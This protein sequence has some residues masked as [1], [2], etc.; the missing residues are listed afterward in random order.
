MMFAMILRCASTGSGKRAYT[1]T[2]KSL[3]SKSSLQESLP[4]STFH[5]TLTAGD[6]LS[7]AQTSGK[8]TSEASRNHVSA[9]LT[10]ISQPMRIFREAV[11][12]TWSGT[13]ASTPKTQWKE[14]LWLPL[15]P[16][17]ELPSN[18]LTPLL[19]SPD[20]NFNQNFAHK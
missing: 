6:Q 7:P 11:T 19:M 18:T 15:L 17:N 4:Q 12:A 3:S 2:L 20:I 13:M 14:L 1:P 10:L 5:G 9:P 8:S 16:K